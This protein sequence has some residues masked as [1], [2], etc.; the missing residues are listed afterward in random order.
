LRGFLVFINGLG[1]ILLEDSQGLFSDFFF[2]KI[3]SNNVLDDFFNF[4]VSFREVLVKFL[5]NHL[6]ELFPLLNGLGLFDGGVNLAT[7]F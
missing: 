4:R 2:A 3:I 6:F 5:S 1:D 7:F